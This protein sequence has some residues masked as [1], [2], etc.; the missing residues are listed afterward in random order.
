MSLLIKALDHLDKNKQAEK[1]KKQAGD[2]VADQ[3]LM[4]ELMPAEAQQNAAH[5]MAAGVEDKTT[6]E[7][8]LDDSKLRK[9]ALGSEP[10]LE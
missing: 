1:D 5:N 7:K 9:D 3:A 6:P 10:S 4:L 2:Y 8:S